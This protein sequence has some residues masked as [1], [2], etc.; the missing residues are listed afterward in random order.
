MAK[1]KNKK[2]IDFKKVKLKVGKK[3]LRGNETKTDFSTR[4]IVIKETASIKSDPISS[5]LSS[6]ETTTT[7]VKIIKLTNLVSSTQLNQPD[8]LTGSLINVL[9]R[10]ACDVDQKLR[11]EAFKCLVKALDC[12][13]SNGLS[14]DPS[15]TMILTHAKCGLTNLNP[16]IQADARTLLRYCIHKS[17][18]RMEGTFVQ[19]VLP[20]LQGNPSSL[21][22]ETALEIVEVFYSNNNHSTKPVVC[23]HFNSLENG[24]IPF[25][26][27]HP[28]APVL[29]NLLNMTFPTLCKT[30]SRQT[31]TNRLEEVLKDRIIQLS[32]HE[33][34]MWMM[35]LEEAKELMVTL[36]LLRFLKHKLP[37]EVNK[38]VIEVRAPGGGTKSTKSKAKV[39]TTFVTELNK[40]WT[41]A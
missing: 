11:K 24:L 2:D 19:A 36:K 40:L 20:R 29:S 8:L 1:K 7:T 31:F 28:E 3:I 39:S 23:S 34:S 18:K 21:D 10:Q 30:N 38:P 16:E 35:G 14:L 12:L 27:L 9:S 6:N 5:V 4:K 13:D 41:L 25:A 33:G 26:F 32:R 15:L 37:S 22:M 17:S